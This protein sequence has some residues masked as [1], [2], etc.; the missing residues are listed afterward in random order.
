MVETITGWFVPTG[1]TCDYTNPERPTWDACR[2]TIEMLKLTGVDY[3]FNHTLG[4]WSNPDSD[5]SQWDGI[6]DTWLIHEDFASWDS[7]IVAWSNNNNYWQPIFPSTINIRDFELYAYPNKDIN[8]SWRD[9]DWRDNDPS[10]LVAPYIQLKYVIEPS[11][12]VKAKIRW[13]NPSVEIST[14]I[15][16]STLDIK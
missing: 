10:I 11:L 2:G 7:T 4:G 9:N 3:G 16:L 14:T 15:G 1:A 6:I 5:G 13:E 12:K 8:L